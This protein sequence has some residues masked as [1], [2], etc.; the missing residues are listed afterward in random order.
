MTNT[1]QPSF[2]NDRQGAAAVEF[3]IAMIVLVAIVFGGI[4]FVRVSM[5]RHTVDHAAYLAARDAIVPGANSVDVENRAEQH[6][7]KMGVV[8]AI[9]TV[10][11]ETIVE[12]TEQVEVT[13]TLPV[14][15]NSF[16]VPQ[17]MSGVIR[18]RSTLL[19]ERAPMR[20]S[21]TLPEPP[22]PP[23]VDPPPPADPPPADPPPEDPPPEEPPPEEPP[24]EEPPP[25][26]PP[27]EEPPP[28]DPGNSDPPPEPPP[29]PPSL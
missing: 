6:L 3:A 23:P 1:T 17:F 14:G 28:E 29:P 26:E 27:P 7:A 13:V 2:R 8:D 22:P 15:K 5:L 10:S 19:T 25:E 18:G 9:V 16:V 12:D 11:P 20:M 21:A 4:E 24:P